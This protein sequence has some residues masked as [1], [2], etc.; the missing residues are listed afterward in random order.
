MEKR[1]ILHKAIGGGRT[2]LG[3]R[4]AAIFENASNEDTNGQKKYQSSLIYIQE[5]PFEKAFIHKR[6]NYAEQLSQLHQIRKERQL[7]T[8]TVDKV[9]SKSAT[10][11]NEMFKDCAFIL[12][13]SQNP[14]MNFNDYYSGKTC[15]LFVYDVESSPIILSFYC[16]Q[17]NPLEAEE[18]P[19]GSSIKTTIEKVYE[20]RLVVSY[21]GV[22]HTIFAESLFYTYTPLGIDHYHQLENGELTLY[23]IKR[24]NFG[25]Y[26]LTDKRIPYESLLDFKVENVPSEGSLVRGVPIHYKEHQG[27]FVKIGSCRALMPRTQFLSVPWQLLPQYYPLGVEQDFEIAKVYYDKTS[28]RVILKPVTERIISEEG[29]PNIALLKDGVTYTVKIVKCQKSD[30]GATILYLTGICL[31]EVCRLYSSSL[32]PRLQ[33]LQEEMARI[34]LEIPLTVERIDNHYVCSFPSLSLSQLDIPKGIQPFRVICIVNKLAL[35]SLGNLLAVHQFR[36]WELWQLKRS[37][38][39][40]GDVVYMRVLGVSHDNLLDVAFNDTDVWESCSWKVGDTLEPLGR[41]NEEGVL[42]CDCH[43]VPGA[44]IPLSSTFKMGQTVTVLYVDKAKHLL[45]VTTEP[46]VFT[47]ANEVRLDNKPIIGGDLKFIRESVF[48]FKVETK[49]VIAIVD[50]KESVL[51]R[52]LIKHR[53]R[54]EKPQPKFIIEVIENTNYVIARWNGLIGEEDYFDLTN[55]NKLDVHICERNDSGMLNVSYRQIPGVFPEDTFNCQGDSLI[56]GWDGRLVNNDELFEF[57]PYTEKLKSVPSVAIGKV[58]TIRRQTDGEWLYEDYPVN[59]EWGHPVFPDIDNRVLSIPLSTLDVEVIANDNCLIVDGQSGL[60]RLYGKFSWNGQGVLADMY[61]VGMKDSST[62]IVAGN[63]G[64][65]TI[66]LQEFSPLCSPQQAVSWCEHVKLIP[67]TLK[68]RDISGLMQFLPATRVV[69]SSWEYSML[70]IGDHLTA[71]IVGI[72]KGVMSVQWNSI[73]I[74]IRRNDSVPQPHCRPGDIY[75]VGQMIECSVIKIYP[76]KEK[77][78][79]EVVRNRD[80]IRR[81]IDFEEGSLVDVVVVR[82][83]LQNIIVSHNGVFGI[84]HLQSGANEI[85]HPEQKITARC[86]SIDKESLNI[87]FAYEREH[88]ENDQGV[89]ECVVIEHRRAQVLIVEHEGVRLKM[90]TG[91]I[92]AYAFVP[93]DKI[94]GTF[95]IGRR[96]GNSIILKRFRKS[97]TLQGEVVA[98]Q[99]ISSN[100]YGV[101]IDMDDGTRGFMIAGKKTNRP[102]CFPKGI[103]VDDARCIWVDKNVGIARLALVNLEQQ[104][105]YVGLTINDE[106]AFRIARI[107]SDAL[108]G[109]VDDLYAIVKREEAGWKYSFSD[110]FSLE[111][112]FAIGNR[113]NARIISATNRLELSLK[114]TSDEYSAALKVGKI[115]KGKIVRY[116]LCVED[117]R[118]SYYL[119]EWDEFVGILPLRE[120][121]YQAFA[122]LLYLPGEEVSAIIIESGLDSKMPTL[123]FCKLMPYPFLKANLSI[124][125]SYKANLVGVSNGC[126]ILTLPAGIRTYIDIKRNFSTFSQYEYFINQNEIIVRLKNILDKKYVVELLQP[127]PMG[128]ALLRGTKVNVTIFQIETFHTEI[129]G[130]DAFS[131]DG[132]LIWIPVKTYRASSEDTIIHDNINVG[133]RFVVRLT[134]NPGDWLVK[135]VL[136]KAI[137]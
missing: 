65:G 89:V 90:N 14:A 7:L 109:Y 35:L 20:D 44:L 63:I 124:G 53:T 11:V 133:D 42:I 21:K 119:L 94:W 46:D 95:V 127:N 104:E 8:F 103:R 121:S 105:K 29:T 61:A 135:A 16:P 116:V 132:L 100:K 86:L 71:E 6:T 115:V 41:A 49:Y 18:L 84:I 37:K 87:E 77:F 19:V 122:P 106:V 80:E 126:L 1:Y 123:S 118:M 47:L 99:V 72:E 98:G 43:G 57:V 56:A 111:T 125:K 48:I 70:E 64:A 82:S 40:V 4:S 128:T 134:T 85:F 97:R 120:S 58:I 5:S 9:K 54:F 76:E 33:P 3:S 130:Y 10:L 108:H 52:Y 114:K 92:P 30:D 136:I 68:K 32:P 91:R 129:R 59:I 13:I 26:Y 101:V 60:R 17:T 113:L 25:Y 74:I 24:S 45:L 27:V 102:E 39:K 83:D 131:D 23:V 67:V 38:L 22:C 62:L 88:T 51:L 93:G 112:D 31:S 50:P 28:V 12:P 78:F 96:G 2:I 75:H 73:V 81:K 117:W 15:R 55:G 137:K 79:V 34:N 66:S 110:D 107:D 69:S 36:V